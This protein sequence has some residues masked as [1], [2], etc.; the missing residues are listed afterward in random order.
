MENLSI[1]EPPHQGGGEGGALGLAPPPPAQLPPQMFTTAA[2]LLD[3][4]DKKLMV[5]L[6]DGRKLVG[7]LRSWD[8]FANIVLQSTTERI[9]ALLPQPETTTTDTAATPAPAPAPRGLY[10]DIFHGI[11]LVRG[12]NVLLLGEIDL[13]RDDLPPPG[14]EEAELS[15]VRR[16]AD[17]ARARDRRR[18]KAR[19]RKLAKL[20]FEGDGAGEIVLL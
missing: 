16:L 13:D 18:D 10:A 20:G 3:L 12:E 5:V 6:R 17:E 11:F 4:T 15:R 9:F 2:Q 1:S 19:G 7:V 14:Y 8:Q